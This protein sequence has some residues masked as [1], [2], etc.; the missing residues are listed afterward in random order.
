MVDLRILTAGEERRGLCRDSGISCD[1]LFDLGLS[2]GVTE[3]IAHCKLCGCLLLL[4]LL[5]AVVANG[6][7]A[8]T[9]ES[10]SYF[11][12]CSDG[13]HCSSA[14]QGSYANNVGRRSRCPVLLRVCF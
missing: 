2:W 10:V 5:L 14:Q 7:Y 11:L 12:Q 4:L 3:V 8:E 1:G 6:G 13:Q 9:A